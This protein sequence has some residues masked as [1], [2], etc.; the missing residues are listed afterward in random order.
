MDLLR[1]LGLWDSCT[2]DR[3]P[4]HLKKESF[5][6]DSLGTLLATEP[7]TLEAGIIG[8]FRPALGLLGRSGGLLLAV[9][10]SSALGCRAFFSA[11]MSSSLALL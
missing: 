6:L 8:T 10:D 3:A 9:V 11:A 4:N 2:A 7:R 1:G 5:H